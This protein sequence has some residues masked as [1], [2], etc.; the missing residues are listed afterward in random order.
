MRSK[1]SLLVIDA[2]RRK[3]NSLFEMVPD[4]LREKFDLVIQEN[5]EEIEISL[6]EKP[7]PLVVHLG[8]DG[9]FGYTLDR[10]Y[11]RYRKTNQEMPP[12]LS[13]GGGT[14]NTVLRYLTREGREEEISLESL[15]DLLPQE[16]F[17]VINYQPLALRFGGSERIAGY[18]AGFGH[19]TIG[20][21]QE[22]EKIR[23]RFPHF[24]LF[25]SRLNFSFSEKR[26]LAP[27]KRNLIF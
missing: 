23:G 6:E 21:T 27:T 3:E 19:L 24:L 11:R 4:C 25:V 9:S 17:K 18:L 26:K 1:E 5:L 15:L 2:R 8:G 20:V 13:L 10:L 22:Y 12:I 16:D 14:V 7:F